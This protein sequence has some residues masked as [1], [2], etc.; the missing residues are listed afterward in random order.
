MKEYAIRGWTDD[1]C[2]IVDQV[3]S[4]LQGKYSLLIVSILALEGEKSFGELSRALK[5]LNSKTL[6][7]RLRSLQN[8]GVIINRREMD[9]KIKKSYYKI[10]KGKA[11]ILELLK[12][13]RLYAHKS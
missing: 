3:F 11:E 8:D 2:A 7:D 1:D 10:E 12:A 9:G 6:T 4:K 13:F 5:P